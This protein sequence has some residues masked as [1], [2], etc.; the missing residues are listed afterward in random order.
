MVAFPSPETIS[1]CGLEVC[2]QFLFTHA[3]VKPQLSSH[4]AGTGALS[5]TAECHVY[6]VQWCLPRVTVPNY[7][8]HFTSCRVLVSG[9]STFPSSLRLRHAKFSSVPSSSPKRLEEARSLSIMSDPSLLTHQGRLLP[10]K[11]NASL[12]PSFPLLVFL[13]PVHGFLCVKAGSL[14]TVFGLPV[15]SVIGLF[16]LGRRHQKC[17]LY[18]PHTFHPQRYFLVQI[19]THSSSLIIHFLLTPSLTMLPH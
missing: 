12:S 4:S 16:S 1:L 13:F 14:T 17:C 2:T 15:V 19:L 11:R 18:L 7:P 3:A 9:I 10:R 6:P 5:F 8:D